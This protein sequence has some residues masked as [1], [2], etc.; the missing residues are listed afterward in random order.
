MYAWRGTVGLI[1]PTFRPGSLERF[2]RLM[3][4]GVGVIPRYVGV[5]SGTEHEFEEAVAVAEERVSELAKLAVDVILIQGVPPFMLRGFAADAEI[6]STL[7]RKYGVPVVTATTTQVEAMR[8]FH[9]GRLVGV[10]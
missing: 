1:K 10:T 4:D 6:T 5:R 8:A 3:P 9:D 2:I 7:H